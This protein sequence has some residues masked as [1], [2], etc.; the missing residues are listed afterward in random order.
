MLCNPTIFNQAIGHG[1]ACD[2]AIRGL[3][4]HGKSGEALIFDVALEDIIQGADL[5]RTPMNVLLPSMGSYRSRS[6][7][8]W[9]DLGWCTVAPGSSSG[10]RTEVWFFGKGPKDSFC[11]ERHRCTISI[12]FM[13]MLHA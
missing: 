5:F 1:A 3:L 12:E 11:L 10:I 2:A 6:H 9:R 7:L 8:P 4:H 13:A